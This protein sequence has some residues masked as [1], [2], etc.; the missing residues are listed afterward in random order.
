MLV[1]IVPLIRWRKSSAREMKMK[2]TKQSRCHD[3]SRFSRKSCK[4]S[5]NYQ[6]FIKVCSGFI[7][8]VTISPTFGANIFFGWFSCF[9]LCYWKT[10]VCF[11]SVNYIRV[12]SLRCKKKRFLCRRYASSP[13]ISWLMDEW[14]KHV[15]IVI[16]VTY[17]SCCAQEKLNI[18]SSI[19]EIVAQNL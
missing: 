17:A 11:R 4:K 8:E 3:Y 2:E 6:T 9:F 1:G 13:K 7:F 19:E 10:G 14:A 12:I 15:F 5:I 16:R 18:L